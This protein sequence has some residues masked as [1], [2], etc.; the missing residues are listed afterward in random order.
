V[1]LEVAGLDIRPGQEAAFEKS[2]AQAQNLIALMQGYVS[3]ELR[4]CVENR[5]RYLLLVTWQTLEDHTVGF[6]SSSKYQEW[7]ALLHHYYEPFP[8]VEHYEQVFEC[9]RGFAPI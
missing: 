2:F 7:K 4:Q 9:E 5:S 8:A 1:I 6:R 3:H